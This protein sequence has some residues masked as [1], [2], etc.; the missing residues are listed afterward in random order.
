M[1]QSSKHVKWCLEKA[2]KEIKECK[3]LG[4]RMKHRGLLQVEPNIDEAKKHL[5]KAQHDF[6]A[7]SRFKEIGFSD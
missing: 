7:I 4:E 5:R 6:D 2:D 3:K 1:S